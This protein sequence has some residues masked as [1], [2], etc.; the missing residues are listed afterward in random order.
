[1][2]QLVQAATIASQLQ[3]LTS[4]L[5]DTHLNPKNALH[6][7]EVMPPEPQ[8]PDSPPPVPTTLLAGPTQPLECNS[9]AIPPFH[10]WGTHPVPPA[11]DWLCPIQLLDPSQPL[12]PNQ[13]VDPNPNF[14]QF[15]LDQNR[16]G[17]PGLDILQ[18]PWAE[19]VTCEATQESNGQFD[20][21]M[22]EYT[23]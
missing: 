17:D 15:P 12:D 9:G 8:I 18:N 6:P 16:W 19:S 13:S 23:S 22:H 5:N 21:S 3:A 1:M 7:T 14:P 2:N 4:P 11:S 10:E 20:R